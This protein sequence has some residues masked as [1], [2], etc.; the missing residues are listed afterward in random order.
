VDIDTKDEK[1]ES[2]DAD[3]DETLPMTLSATEKEEI[4]GIQLWKVISE[5]VKTLRT[6]ME[7]SRKSA[8]EAEK[9]MGV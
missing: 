1:P 2:K 4:E 7:E 3:N 6:Q 9:N 5:Q 8:E